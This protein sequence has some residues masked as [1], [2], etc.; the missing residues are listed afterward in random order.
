M[1]TR[2]VSL[3]GGYWLCTISWKVKTNCLLANC[4]NSSLLYS[5]IQYEVS[6]WIS[7]YTLYGVQWYVVTVYET[8]QPYYTAWLVH[9]G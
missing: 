1:V 8:T 3:F 9:I 7:K 2:N 5:A 4:L 6:K